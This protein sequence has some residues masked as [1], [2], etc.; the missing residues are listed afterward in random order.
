MQSSIVDTQASRSWIRRSQEHHDTKVTKGLR[1]PRLFGRGGRRRTETKSKSRGLVRDR[2]GV[3][4]LGPS[5]NDD[6]ELVSS[7]FLES[8]VENWGEWK[9]D[10]TTPCNVDDSQSTQQRSVRSDPGPRRRL[11]GA[12][13]NPGGFLQNKKVSTQWKIPP[14]MNRIFDDKKEFTTG[15][16]ST[17]QRSPKK[18][19]LKSTT[20]TLRAGNNNITNSSVPS[21]MTEFFF[22][23]LQASSREKEEPNFLMKSPAAKRSTNEARRP[24]TPRNTAETEQRIRQQAFD[25]TRRT[26]KFTVPQ[27]RIPV[28]KDE[29]LVVVEVEF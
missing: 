2:F 16:S 1:Y 21:N 29:S 12:K 26:S 11:D 20:S 15:A 13:P 4:E 23:H 17:K 9:D 24:A 3:I 7:E 25:S 5:M 22:D 28:S 10:A 14:E 19:F 8:R 6:S 27:L 18:S